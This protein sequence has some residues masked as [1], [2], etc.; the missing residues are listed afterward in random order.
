MVLVGAPSLPASEE[1]G[2]VYVFERDAAGQWNATQTI[3]P[4]SEAADGFLFGAA[5]SVFKA[6]AET[7]LL[8][9][10]PAERDPKGNQLPFGSVHMYRHVDGSWSFQ[11]EEISSIS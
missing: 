11:V 6:G 1:N 3:Q 8:V 5:L 4:M 7:V 9:G 2:T 10:S